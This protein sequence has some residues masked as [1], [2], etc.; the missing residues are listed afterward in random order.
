MVRVDNS[1][2]MCMGGKVGGCAAGWLGSIGVVSPDKNRELAAK[3][4][5]F[6]TERLGLDADRIYLRF[7]DVQRAWL[8]RGGNTF[9]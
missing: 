8:S 3:L 2:R 1:A 4:T 9:A 5:A 7:E 6:L